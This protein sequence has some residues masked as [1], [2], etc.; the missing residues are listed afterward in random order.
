MKFL[1][2]KSAITKEIVLTL[3]SV[4][5]ALYFA[6]KITAWAERKKAATNER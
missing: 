6:P 3:I 4:G 1:P 2:S 5:V